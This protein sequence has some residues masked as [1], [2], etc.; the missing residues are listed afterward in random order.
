MRPLVFALLWSAV[1]AAREQDRVLSMPGMP[2]LLSPWYSGHLNVSTFRHLHYVFVES[3]RNATTDTLIIWFAGGQGF[4]TMPDLFFGLGPFS[5]DHQVNAHSLTNESSVLYIDNPAGTG[6]SYAGRDI[7]YYQ[8]D[9]QASIDAMTFIKLFFEHWP[10]MKQRP[11]FIAGH[12]YG[13][14]Y[15]PYLAWQIH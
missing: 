7:D 15:A 9:L 6:Y 10:D 2:P 14:V 11:V 8:T 4:S 12:S 3:Q 5:M 1:F 13:G